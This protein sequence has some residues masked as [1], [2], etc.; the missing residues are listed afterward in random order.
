MATP[1]IYS[2][3]I[4]DKSDLTREELWAL[5]FYCFTNA[6]ND[7]E[8]WQIKVE[9]KYNWISGSH[10]GEDTGKFYNWLVKKGMDKK[11]EIVRG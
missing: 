7:D 8:N 5:I 9:D 6:D 2:N 10:T 11:I 1:T 3:F 4:V